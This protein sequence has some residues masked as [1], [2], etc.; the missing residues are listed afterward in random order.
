MS[1]TNLNDP[2]K[3]VL[4]AGGTGLLGTELSKLLTNKGYTV[5]HLSRNPTQKSYQTFYWD[6]KKQE[7]DD[8][9]IKSADA[10][11]H[12]AGAG[13]ADKRWSTSWKKE[14]Y[15]SRINSTKLLKQRV[16]KLNPRLKHYISASAV[17][18]Y[19]WDSGNRLMHEED[20]KGSGFLADVVNDWEAEADSFTDLN[21]K[22]SKVRIGIVLSEKGGALEE[23]AKPVKYGFGAP[24]G[25]GKQYMS[26]IHIQD[27]CGIFS[28]ILE[29]G[30]EGTFNGVASDPKTNKEF[31]GAL[32]K[33]LNRPLW[34][35]NVPKFALRLLVGEMADILIGGNRVSSK[36]IEEAGFNFQ[37]RALDHAL[38]DLLH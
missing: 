12:L 7:I 14:I 26:W 5:T 34:L 11:I 4:I 38:K 13:V 37:F 2:I 25:N 24:L 9:A 35:P 15:N 31:T 27:L 32:A 6:V 8:E 23:I 10:I 28:H 3:T 17:G 30:Q 29:K 20:P 33:S 1:S 18:Y 16:E 19:G 22:V 36:K 21:V